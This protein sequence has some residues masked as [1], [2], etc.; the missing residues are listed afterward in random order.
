LHR[1]MLHHFFAEH[2]P[3]QSEAP[4]AITPPAVA[5]NVEHAHTTA[6]QLQ[7]HSSV[8]SFINIL[9]TVGIG[10]VLVLGTLCVYKGLENRTFTIEKDTALFSGEIATCM[11]IVIGKFLPGF[12]GAFAGLAACF[13][14][15][16]CYYM[17]CSL[18]KN[19]PN[20]FAIV[21]FC[22]VAWSFVALWYGSSL[23][24]FWAATLCIAH[25]FVTTLTHQS[26]PPTSEHT[27]NSSRR[28]QPP[29]STSESSSSSAASNTTSSTRRAPPPQDTQVRSFLSSSLTNTYH[30][31]S[32]GTQHLV[33]HCCAWGGGSV[34]VYLSLRCFFEAVHS[35]LLLSFLAPFHF[36]ILFTGPFLFAV[37]ASVLG[38]VN[39]PRMPLFKQQ[40]DALFRNV[41]SF[42]ALF[43]MMVLGNIAPQADLM[44]K[45]LGTA[46]VI[47]VLIRYFELMLLAKNPI[48]AI[49]TWIG[50]GAL[51]VV[52]GVTVKLLPNLFFLQ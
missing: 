29:H 33:L 45:V 37:G 13:A 46:F 9:L 50:A 44:S 20:I 18:K 48:G 38:F 47:N 49:E 36:G 27:T 2:P 10:M 17:S 23:I 5:N 52:V 35:P 51:L 3:H 21:V 41:V 7:H 42:G 24:G 40:D 28:E 1:H 11:L 32:K 31:F 43:I 30:S 39:R 34:L 6:P 8:F 22:D 4:R 14:I 25:A 15:P 16:C 12:L 26:S 19:Q